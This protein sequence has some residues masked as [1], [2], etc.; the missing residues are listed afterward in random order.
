MKFIEAREQ[1]FRFVPGQA[2]ITFI[3]DR[4]T[5]LPKGKQ[6]GKSY[7][8]IT[9]K[10]PFI[11]VS[12]NPFRN[13]GVRDLDIL[14]TILCRSSITTFDTYNISDSVDGVNSQTDPF[15]IDALLFANKGRISFDLRDYATSEVSLELLSTFLAP[16]M[17][18]IRVEYYSC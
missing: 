1:L 18:K 14:R 17:L 2:V 10:D 4:V 16:F 5:Q 9:V 13:T 8:S 11:V 3:T 6:R 7:K 15:N 12:I